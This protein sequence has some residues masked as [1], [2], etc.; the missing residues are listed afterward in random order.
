MQ[1]TDQVTKN[2]PAKPYNK[3]ETLN[4]EESADGQ[5]GGV[6]MEAKIFT[7][8]PCKGAKSFGPAINKSGGTAEGTLPPSTRAVWVLLTRR[9]FSSDG[10]R[11]TT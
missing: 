6:R 5:R 1:I 11:A 4:L 10:S 8:S 3:T 2:K 9:T 7:V